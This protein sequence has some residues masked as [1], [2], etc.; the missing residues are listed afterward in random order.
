MPPHNVVG[1]V[2]RDGSFL[3]Q[4]GAAKLLMGRKQKPHSYYSRYAPSRS[5]V[6][7]RS[8][9]SAT[10][11]KKKKRPFFSSSMG[12][13]AETTTTEQPHLQLQQELPVDDALLQ[14]RPQTT[15]VTKEQL[16]LHFRRVAV[17]MVG[18]GFMDQTIMIQAG[19]AI[20]CTLG[21][22]LGLSTLSAA[23][24]GQIVS[25]GTNASIHVKALCVCPFPV[26]DGLKRD[27]VV[28]AMSDIIFV[29]Q[30]QRLTSV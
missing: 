25:N 27:R 9:L 19:N 10:K 7:R 14:L 3:F 24:F 20:D 21:V 16:R 26:T 13:A 2:R 22:T 28:I 18:F 11:K 1:S 17:P 6:A 30:R 5:A 12:G 15:T 29:R 8:V 4:K 23:A